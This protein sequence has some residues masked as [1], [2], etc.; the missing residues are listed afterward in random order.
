MKV[1]SIEN[2]QTDTDNSIIYI[3]NADSNKLLTN[4]KYQD[5]D[6]LVCMYDDSI[7][8]IENEENSELINFSDRDVD[9]YTIM[10]NNNVA[11]IEEKSSGLFTADSEIT[12]INTTS[13]KETMYTIEDVAKEIYSCEDVLGLNL[14]SELHFI[15]TGGW[16]VKRYIANQEISNVVMSDS[17]AGIIYRDKIEVID[18]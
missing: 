10:L 5:K 13:G 11:L 7:C 9:F 12:F 6:K 1:V 2:A 3:Y 14:G 8:I 15:N 4:I 16:L 18:L 17:I